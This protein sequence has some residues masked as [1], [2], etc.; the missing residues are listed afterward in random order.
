M[1]G[2]IVFR[3]SQSTPEVK[4]KEG[5]QPRHAQ[6]EGIKIQTGGQMIGGVSTAKELDPALRYAGNYG[7]WVYV[8]YVNDGIDVL[9]YM[10]ERSKKWFG[11]GKWKAGL[12]N[13]RTQAEIAAPQVDGR[14]VIAA[15]EARLDGS[16]I[17]FTG[18]VRLN[19]TS[20]TPGTIVPAAKAMEAIKLL[21]GE[22]EVSKD[23]H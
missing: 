5:F 22:L 23:Y 14:Q 19:W 16:T 7:G 13:A 11:G 2:V 18:K 3:G 6:G 8:M 12:A 9:E 10:L 17:R 21:S 15:R 1:S 20:A 4:F